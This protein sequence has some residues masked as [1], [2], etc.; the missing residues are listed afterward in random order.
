MFF[1]T[2]LGNL[3]YYKVQAMAKK[4]A[5]STKDFYTRILNLINYGKTFKLSLLPGT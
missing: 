4:Q 5:K 1:F 2:R 3:V